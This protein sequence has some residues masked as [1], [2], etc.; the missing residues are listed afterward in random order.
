MDSVFIKDLFQALSPVA[1]FSFGLAGS[2]HSVPYAGLGSGVCCQ[3]RFHSVFGKTT[4]A[5][6][7]FNN[8]LPFV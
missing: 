3:S 8:A 5:D 4:T 6:L 2:I 1:F 7:L